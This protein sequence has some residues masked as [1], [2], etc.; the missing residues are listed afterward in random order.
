MLLFCCCCLHVACSGWFFSLSTA[1]LV[2]ELIQYGL[3]LEQASS[4]TWIFISCRG[5]VWSYRL[6]AQHETWDPVKSWL[7]D[8]EDTQRQIS[9]QPDKDV[10]SPQTLQT[11]TGNLPF[12]TKCYLKPNS[13]K[14]VL[15]RVF[16]YF[17]VPVKFACPSKLTHFHSIA[18]YRSTN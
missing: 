13:S 10:G 16:A 6:N 3:S 18:A 11:M 15:F 14:Q 9:L 2:C 17:K 7:K 8:S 1:D 5:T 4:L 12:K